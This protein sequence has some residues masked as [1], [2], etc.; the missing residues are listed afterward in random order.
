METVRLDGRDWVTVADAAELGNVRAVTIYQN[1]RRGRL[2]GR[3]YMRRLAVP[4]DEVMA[5][6]PADE[7][8]VH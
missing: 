2:H 5:L 6:W 7:P 4:L 1:I 8:E 3:L